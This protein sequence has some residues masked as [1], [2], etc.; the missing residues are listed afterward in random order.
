MFFDV[1]S[2]IGSNITNAIRQAAEAT[3]AGFD[4]LLKTALRESNLDPNAKATGS[5]AGGLFQF[6]DQTWLETLKEAGPQ[7]G[8]GSY[9]DSIVKTP[10]GHY[11]V[12]DPTM[13]QAVMQLRY[14]PT[15]NAAMAGAYTA[16]NAIELAS[17]L[18]RK[19]TD[20]ELYIAHFLGA[21]GAVK[22][23][24]AASQTPDASAADLFPDAARANRS[25]FYDKQGSPRSVGDVYGALV[26]QHQAGGSSSTPAPV[27]TPTTLPFGLFG[28]DTRLVNRDSTPVFHDL[29]QNQP[30]GPISPL[31]AALWGDSPTT[32]PLL[33][34]PVTPGDTPNGANKPIGAPGAPLDLFGFLRQEIRDANKP[35]A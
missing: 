23:I 20:G 5:S 32:G 28:Q 13:R 25:I 34:N 19:A 2:D 3:G 29:F 35:G 10:S 26:A 9:A 16:R 4:Y 8:Y 11:A 22:L 12:P 27:V 17:G 33:S 24:S 15:A 21:A 18:G 31:V 7:L 30:R 14:D 6:V 1:T